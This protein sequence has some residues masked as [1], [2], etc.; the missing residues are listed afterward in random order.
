[1]EISIRRDN[2]VQPTGVSTF[3]ITH[4]LLIYFGVRELRFAQ[5]YAQTKNCKRASSLTTRRK[6]YFLKFLPSKIF[7]TDNA[8]AKQTENDIKSPELSRRLKS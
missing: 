8:L 6:N 2:L 7:K 3:A 4:G 1:M 5:A